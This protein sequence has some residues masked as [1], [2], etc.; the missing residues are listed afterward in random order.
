M[1]II[2]LTAWQLLA[3]IVGLEIVSAPIIIVVVNSVI[4]GY[5]RYKEQHVGRMAKAIGE[6]MENMIKAIESKNKKEEEN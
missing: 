5:F 3:W 2:N 4:S 1:G 6:A